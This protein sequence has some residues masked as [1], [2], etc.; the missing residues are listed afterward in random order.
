MKK[1]P[2]ASAVVSLAALGLAGTAHLN[3]PSVQDDPQ[4]SGD[5]IAV[6]KVVSEAFSDNTQSGLQ[7]PGLHIHIPSVSDII[8]KVEGWVINSAPFQLVKQDVNSAHNLVNR[9]SSI[10]A[11]V[12]T[13]SDKIEEEVSVAI[14]KEIEPELEKVLKPVLDTVFSTFLDEW[15][16]LVK[17]V[18]GTFEDVAPDYLEIH[19]G[20]I[21]LQWNDLDLTKL[22]QIK[23]SIDETPDD[24]VKILETLAPDQVGI[25]LEGSIGFIFDTT[26]TGG[27][28][29]FLLSTEDFI[30]WWNDNSHLLTNL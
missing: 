29:I 27:E 5:E 7:K 23:A 28:L 20:F 1:I 18:I 25:D 17:D 10:E 12:Q 4:F 21:M 8:K 16:P 22:N 26:D 15:K 2:I 19:V 14:T 3:T 6:L 30:T 9:V 11:E 13:L 24:V